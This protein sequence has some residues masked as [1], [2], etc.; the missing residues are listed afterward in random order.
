MLGAAG[1]HSPGLISQYSLLGLQLI[2]SPLERVRLLDSIISAT[3]LQWGA[4]AWE[5]S[6]NAFM[7]PELRASTISI[8]LKIAVA[9]NFAA[10]ILLTIFHDLS[11]NPYDI[12]ATFM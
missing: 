5:T 8:G 1:L 6:S 10:G 2:E 11:W 9:I 7:P 4:L 12:G 3:A